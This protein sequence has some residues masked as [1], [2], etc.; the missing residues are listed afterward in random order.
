MYIR[1]IQVSLDLTPEEG[2]TVV[3][4]YCAYTYN[5]SYVLYTPPMQATNIKEKCLQCGRM[6][7][8]SH[9]RDHII[10]F[11]FGIICN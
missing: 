10:F 8:I 3:S 6:I 2:H 1:P 11:K 7:A 5:Y 4:I 9:L